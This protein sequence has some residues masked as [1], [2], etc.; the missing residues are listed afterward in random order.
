[1]IKKVVKKSQ[2][3]RLIDSQSY[4]SIE[5]YIKIVKDKEREGKKNSLANIKERK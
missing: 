1:L 5:N 4:K 3:G 2:T